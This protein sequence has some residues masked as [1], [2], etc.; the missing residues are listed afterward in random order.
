MPEMNGKVENAISLADIS[1]WASSSNATIRG[2]AGK[3]LFKDQSPEQQLQ[4][5]QAILGSNSNYAEELLSKFK[6]V[7]QVN[8]LVGCFKS[9][10]EKITNLAAGFADRVI[11]SVEQ[12]GLAVETDVKDLRSIAARKLSGS[13][14]KEFA[15]NY[16]SP[17]AVTLAGKVFISLTE[18]EQG[19]I[20]LDLFS[21]KNGWE[22]VSKLVKVLPQE[23]ALSQVL[24]NAR[25]LGEQ[26]VTLGE[27]LASSEKRVAT[28]EAEND[29]YKNQVHS[30]DTDFQSG[31][32]YYKSDRELQEE[33][34]QTLRDM[35]S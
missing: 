31:R 33:H 32:A 17:V 35:T 30:I 9:A 11:Q 7:T 24:Q 6:A 15:L 27:R 19:Q 29:R 34:F 18:P 28:L 2:E 4:I 10:D 14:L 22:P 8:L 25:S 16:S 21:H 12:I 3:I 26:V 23:Q 1:S 20:M 13:N 5:F